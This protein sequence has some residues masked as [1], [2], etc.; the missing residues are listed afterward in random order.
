MEMAGNLE[1]GFRSEATQTRFAA[2]LV[3]LFGPLD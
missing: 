3:G 2:P 1:D